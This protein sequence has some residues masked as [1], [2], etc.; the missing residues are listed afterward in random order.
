MEKLGL[1]GDELFLED[2]SHGVNHIISID[3]VYAS[4][5]LDE[6]IKYELEDEYKEVVVK[7]HN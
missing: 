4:H 3:P 6:I 2:I 1:S 5:T 7:V